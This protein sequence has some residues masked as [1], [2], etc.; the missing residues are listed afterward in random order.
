MHCT[1]CNKSTKYSSKKKTACGE[2]KTVL[3]YRCGKCVKLFGNLNSLRHHLTVICNKEP[4][5][6]CDYCGRKIF[7]K[8]DLAKHIIRKHLP[9]NSNLNKCKKC[10]KSFSTSSDL[11]RHSKICGI[12]KH[13][14]N[15]PTRFY[16][17]Q[18]DFKSHYKQPLIKH[19][20][21]KHLPR[22][23]NLNKCTK[24]TKSFSSKQN[25]LKHIKICGLTADELS[26]RRALHCDDCE[27]KTRYK[28]V[29]AMHVQGHL[30]RNHDS[31]SNECIKC[32]V[33]F[34][35]SDDLRIHAN[36][37]R[38]KL[39]RKTKRFSCHLCGFRSRN[40]YNLRDHI[41]A[42][43]MPQDPNL[44]KCKKCGKN[45]SRESHLYRHSKVCGQSKEFIRSLW[46]YACEHCSFKTDRKS[47]LFDHLYG[48]H[49]ARDP[50]MN[51][52]EKCGKTFSLLTYLIAHSKICDF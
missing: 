35:N 2:C 24:C 16:C 23:K 42:I 50:N 41:Q 26:N 43:H 45:Y 15:L 31:T 5:F 9:R 20:K 12:P 47:H 14:K 52:C 19:V 28:F 18:C 48:T 1:K 36:G 21:A 13:L 32:K 33:T 38:E 51:K 46:R 4:K 11:T 40:K 22:N 44:N 27:Y 3:K 39:S 6:G 25:L 34:K 30:P 8:G 10:K 17:D 49:F 29:L 37:C 7:T